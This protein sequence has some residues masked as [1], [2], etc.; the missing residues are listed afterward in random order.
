MKKLY[1]LAITFVI[2]G[3]MITSATSLPVTS[4]VEEIPTEEAVQCVWVPCQLVKTVSRDDSTNGISPL[5]AGNQI[6]AGDY[7]EFRPTIAADASGRFF[8]SFDG[9]A[10][11]GE[12]YYPIFTYTEDSGAT[13]ADPVYFPDSAGASKPDVDFKP[14]GFYATFS[15]SVDLN[16]QIWVIDASVIEDPAGSMW[17]FGPNNIDSFQDMHIATYTHAGPTDDGAWNWGGL[18]FTGY[19]GYSNP[20]VVGCPFTFYQYS[21][22]GGGLIGWVTNTDGCAHASI[23]IDLVTN[24]SY[25]AYDRSVTGVYQLLIRKDN[26]GVWTNQGDYYS[27]PM[28][29]TKKITGAGNL[30]YPD[31]IADSNNVLVVAQNDEAGNQ[32]IICYYSTN[33]M[34]SYNNA[35][36]SD[37][38]EDELYPQITWIKSGVAV[39]TYIRGTE[40]YCKSTEDFGVTWSTEQRVSDEQLDP[41]EDHAM[42]I[43]G[44]NGNAYAIWQDGRGANKDIFWDSFYQV[45]APNVQ[46]GT[47]AGGIGK[48]TMEILNSGTGE[49]TDVDWSITVTG[50]IL[51]KIN[52]VTT[53]TEASIAAGGS[54]T[55]QTDKFIFGLGKLTIQLTAGAATASK[56]GK[57]LL[58]LVTKIA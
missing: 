22:E 19:N 8:I 52:V 38:A 33:G 4:D 15:P 25:S 9:R 55:V 53:G 41:V 58:F 34:S 32:D 21:A 6:T 39:C 17:D 37:A 57:I 18:A 24:M 29:T 36:I 26:Y 48:V 11:E 23:D 40:A 43:C 45:S 14:S 20:T 27:H 46:I 28:S 51:N 49:A 7:D 13:W 2:A 47:V 30:T 3:L 31:V 10:D 16:G 5:F 35:I 44:I 50:G 56:T 1:L 12:S 42:T 54:T